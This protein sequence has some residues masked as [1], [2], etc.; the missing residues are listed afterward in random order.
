MPFKNELCESEA[1]QDSGLRKMYFVSY[2]F[3]RQYETW[4]QYKSLTTEQ[5][6]TL[7]H[8]YTSENCPGPFLDLFRSNVQNIQA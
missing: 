7:F 3:R 4:Y 6:W 1:N 5:F 8:F 2:L